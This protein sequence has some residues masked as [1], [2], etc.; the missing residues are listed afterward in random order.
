MIRSSLGAVPSVGSSPLAAAAPGVNINSGRPGGVLNLAR[1][2]AA[3]C[4]Q[5]QQRL[6]LREPSLS[7]SRFLS[8]TAT[9]ASPLPL[10]HGAAGHL[11]T[12][13]VR[14]ARKMASKPTLPCRGVGETNVAGHGTLAGA[15]GQAGGNDGLDPH[16]SAC[17][18][19]GG[20]PAQGFIQHDPGYARHTR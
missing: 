11:C 17:N 5:Q 8:N 1:P 3:H 9:A 20:R 16:S 15:H 6:E 14:G 13:E 7:H 10:E 19:H 4:E 18:K 12:G 2:A